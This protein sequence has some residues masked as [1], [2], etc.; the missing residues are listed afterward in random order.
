MLNFV[1]QVV[2]RFLEVTLWLILIIFASVGGVIGWGLDEEA[3]HAFLGVILG[4]II[5]F[6]FNIIF[7]GILVIFV[8]MGKE[9]SN[10]EIY[11]KKISK[12]I[13]SELTTNSNVPVA[14]SAVHSSASGDVSFEVKHVIPSH[15]PSCGEQVEASSA[16]VRI[17]KICNHCGARL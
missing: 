11:V 8:N 6:I 5:G 12:K 4:I 10:I 16:D 13:S 15:C 14:A 7:G 17:Y 1:A 9:I 2:E 3:G